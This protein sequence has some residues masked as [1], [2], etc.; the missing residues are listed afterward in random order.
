MR[1]LIAILVLVVASPASADPETQA[2]MREYFAGEQRGGFVLVGMGA[3]GLAAGGIALAEGSQ[4]AEGASYVLFAMGTVH[5]AAGVFVYVASRGRV[6]KF[7]PEIDRDQAAFVA[8]ESKRMKGVSRGFTTL[9]IVE[10]ILIAG[11]ITVGV[12]ANTRD[13]PRLEGAGYAVAVEAAATLAFDIVA[14]RRAHRYR[15]RLAP[16]AS[17][18][19]NAITLGIAGRF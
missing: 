17:V 11:G 12:V 5:V 9:K 6:R 7:G 1:A 8:R 16:R 15:E 19:D 10:V 3:A 13:Q 4:R 2:A 18:S 14:A